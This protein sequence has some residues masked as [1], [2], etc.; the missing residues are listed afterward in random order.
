MNFNSV[1]TLHFSEDEIERLE[2]LYYILPEFN[3]NLRD[4][5]PFVVFNQN[6]RSFNQNFDSLSV[7]LSEIEKNIKIIVLTET[8]F[9]KDSC[10]SI[11][12]YRGYHSYRSDK[13]GGGVSVHV[14]KNIQSLCLHEFTACTEVYESCVIEVCPNIKI[15]SKT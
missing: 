13:I 3:D 4:H 10:C 12:G 5:K 6:I 8:W 11:E 7:F 2:S 1:F 9:T 15:S 14:R